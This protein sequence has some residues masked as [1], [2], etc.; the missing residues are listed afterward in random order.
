MAVRA[1]SAGV[2]ALPLLMLAGL[3]APAALAA[4][5]IGATPLPFTPTIRGS[6]GQTVVSITL[7]PGAQPI[8]LT[9][10]IQST[11]GEPGEILVTAGGQTI[12]SVPAP[13]GGAVNA[14]IPAEAVQDGVIAIGMQVRLEPSDDCRVDE[15]ATA[16]FTDALLTYERDLAP[17]TTIGVFL[18]LIHI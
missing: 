2:L 16:T 11:Y 15:G 13:D 18:S 9:G 1:R 14:P 10:T 6:N 5:G 12:A 7:P 3:V 8:R 17:P 4:D